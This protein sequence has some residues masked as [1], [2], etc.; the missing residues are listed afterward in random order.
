[1][2]GK[3]DEEESC[4]DEDHCCPPVDEDESCA[5]EDHCCPPVA[6]DESCADEDHCCP[7]VPGWS[8]TTP[9]PRFGRCEECLSLQGGFVDGS[10]YSF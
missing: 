10:T 4:A 5:D 1:M 2:A 6:E 3:E 7:P 9:L 8:D